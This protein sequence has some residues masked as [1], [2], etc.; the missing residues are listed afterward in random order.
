MA[1]SGVSLAG[2]HSQETV[3]RLLLLALGVVLASATAS[4]AVQAQNYPWCAIY[5]TGFEGTN[6]GFLSFRQCLADVSGIGG[7]C[8][9]NNLYQPPPG[10]HR[11]RR[12]QP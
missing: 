3:M 5:G 12:L 9:P 1:G 2:P 11:T 8:E 4:T 10:P 7:F 6:C